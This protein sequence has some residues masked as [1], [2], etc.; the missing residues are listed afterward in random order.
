[1]TRNLLKRV[2][3]PMAIAAAIGVTAVALVRGVSRVGSPA[4]SFFQT[5]VSGQVSAYLLDPRG[6]VDGLLLTSGDQ[7]RFGPQ[8]G[9]ALASVVKVGDEVTATGRAGTASSYGR[10]I[11]VKSLSANG[12]TFTE[13]GRGGPH[14]GG[15]PHHGPRGPKGHHGPGGPDSPDGPDGPDGPDAPGEAITAT[16]AVAAHL[17]NREGEVDGL[18]LASGEQVRF[19][20]EVGV[21]VVAAEAAGAT[22]ATVEGPGV[23]TERG[24]MV[25]AARIQIGDQTITTAGR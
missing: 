4:F 17:V 12:Q 18:L 1:M 8:T 20:P 3:L 5:T 10:E 22:S 21:L 16:G 24:T 11:R 25:R 19:G 6:G 9:A 23:R 13:L 2:V 15:P 7:L 14:P